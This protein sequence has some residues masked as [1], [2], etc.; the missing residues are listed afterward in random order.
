MPCILKQIKMINLSQSLKYKDYDFNSGSFS[1]IKENDL[2]ILNFRF[3]NYKINCNY[4]KNNRCDKFITITKIL[5]MDQNFNIID[6]NKLIIPYYLQYTSKKNNKKVIGIEDMRFFMYNNKIKIIGSHENNDLRVVIGEYDYAQNKLINVNYIIPSFN[7]QS[8]E[9]NWTYVECNNKLQ[10]I[11]KWDPLQICESDDTNKLN[12]IKEV[13]MPPFFKNARGSTCGVHYNNEIWFI[14]HFNNDGVY[15]HFFAV[16]D[17]NMNLIK[18]SN[19]FLFEGNK[20]EF[21]IGLYINNDVFLIPYSINDTISKLGIYD[22]HLINNM[23]WK[24][25]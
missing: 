14:V 5:K 8:V 6:E 10:I 12:I 16:F 9:K 13:I 2:Y 11:Y 15:S 22:I 7:Y 25:I 18:F 20:I 1:I 4:I 21:C 17:I 23:Q 3:V 24:Y 19:K